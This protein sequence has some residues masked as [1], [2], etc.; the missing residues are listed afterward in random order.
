MPNEELGR[1][2]QQ[3][4]INALNFLQAQIAKYYGNDGILSSKEKEE[5][6]E[7]R[8]SLDVSESQYKRLVEIA[9]D[10]IRNF[11]KY[12]VVSFLLGRED[13]LKLYSD[14]E[15]LSIRISRVE[16]WVSELEDIVNP[17]EDEKSNKNEIRIDKM[18]KIVKWFDQEMF[19]ETNADREAV[20]KGG[21][22]ELESDELIKNEIDD[23]IN[24][25]KNLE[26]RF[27]CKHL[28]FSALNGKK[29]PKLESYSNEEIESSLKIV[30]DAIKAEIEK[31]KNYPPIQYKTFI[32]KLDS[33]S[34]KAEFAKAVEKCANDLNIKKF[35]SPDEKKKLDEIL[36][37]IR[38]YTDL[39][40]LFRKKG[41]VESKSEVDLEKHL[42]GCLLYV[43]IVLIFFYIV[44][45]YFFKTLDLIHNIVATE[46]SFKDSRDSLEYKA[47]E[48]N[49][50]WWMAYNLDY[51]TKDS[52]SVESKLPKSGGRFYSWN[53]AVKACPSG[54]RLPTLLEWQ[55]L[56]KYM[57]ERFGDDSIAVVALKSR[58]WD[59]SDS[60]GFSALPTGY[61]NANDKV[62]AIR[63]QDEK[64]SWWTYA[65]KNEKEAY[66][67]SIGKAKDGVEFKFENFEYDYRSVR[68]VKMDGEKIRFI[69][70]PEP[71]KPDQKRSKIKGVVA[72]FKGDRLPVI[73]T[74]N[75]TQAVLYDSTIF[76]K[77][78]VD[79]MPVFPTNANVESVRIYETAYSRNGN[80]WVKDNIWR[81][82]SIKISG[83]FTVVDLV[84]ERDSLC[85]IGYG[86]L[87]GADSIVA[88]LLLN[89]P[90]DSL[91][92]GNEYLIDAYYNV[93]KQSKCEND[94]SVINDSLLCRFVGADIHA[95]K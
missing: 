35:L 73:K 33:A 30:Y 89:Y 58:S 26:W 69:S 7:L 79:Q 53:N 18:N 56:A 40:K 39:K 47:V 84:A 83:K 91:K 44:D 60:I 65:M 54:W 24:E 21:G 87:V 70:N 42:G 6:D 52:G 9:K 57:S 20:E 85:N 67:A 74:P 2:E 59:G 92:K 50:V 1:K 12:D 19:V 34:I 55:D 15:R 31:D 61:Y 3:Q 66:I 95:D 88:K 68:C 16:R 29:E 32:N 8:I 13:K 36:S 90:C 27:F 17:K 14:A 78:N 48:I 45:S 76:S 51:D 10:E 63:E 64:A 11:K 37:R 25:E 43:L 38:Q 22:E 80:V 82:D 49:G 94:C 23:F 41:Y 72:G 75:G 62:R 71:E 4:K 81:E 46:I 86:T 93:Y 28:L 77:A 5:L